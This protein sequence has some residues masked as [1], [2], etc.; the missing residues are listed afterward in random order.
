MTGLPSILLGIF[1]YQMIVIGFDE[2]GIKLPGIG[3]SGLAGSFAIG[4][5]MIPII[6][7]LLRRHCG[8]SLP[9]FGKLAWHWGRAGAAAKKD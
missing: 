2:W 5:L 7:K 8:A 3:F 9:Q 4:V 1:V 6:M